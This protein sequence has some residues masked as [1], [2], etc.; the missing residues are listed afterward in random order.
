MISEVLGFSRFQRMRTL[1]NSLLRKC[2]LERSPS[3][4]LDK[5]LLKQLGYTQSSQEK[6][7]VMGFSRKYLRLWTLMTYTRDPHGF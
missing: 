4:G 7:E 5:L 3:V 1:R 6:A 2:V